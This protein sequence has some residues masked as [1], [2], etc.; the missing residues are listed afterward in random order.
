[1]KWMK[2]L[3]LT[4]LLLAGCAN[5]GSNETVQKDQEPLM[6]LAPSGAPA[7][8]LLPLYGNYDIETVQGSDVITAELARTDSMY[9]VIVAPINTGTKL[10]AEEKFTAPTEV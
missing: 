6:I 5:R 4:L 1:M 2:G 8:A 7:L 3:L 9:D 10:L